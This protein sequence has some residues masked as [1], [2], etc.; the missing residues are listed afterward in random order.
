MPR[1]PNL[2]RIRF[3]KVGWSVIFIP[4][5]D[6][7]FESILLEMNRFFSFSPEKP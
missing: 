1:I 4:I 5:T 2:V 3:G 7:F 6:S